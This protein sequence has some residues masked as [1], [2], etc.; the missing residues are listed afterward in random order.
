MECI[1]GPRFL[2][3]LADIFSNIS[4]TQKTIGTAGLM[5]TANPMII[6]HAENSCRVLAG[7]VASYGK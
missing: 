6:V 2:H 1:I 5:T 4:G 3:T 7:Q